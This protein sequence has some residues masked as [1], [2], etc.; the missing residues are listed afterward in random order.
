M[1]CGALI[2]LE[3][4]QHWS[5][6]TCRQAKIEWTSPE[7]AGI[8]AYVAGWECKEW[9]GQ[10]SALLLQLCGQEDGAV[11]FNAL[12]PWSGMG[13]DIRGAKLT[14]QDMAQQLIRTHQSLG[15]RKYYGNLIGDST[16][17]GASPSICDG[18]QE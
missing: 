9:E 6:F 8:P 18:P 14:T 1:N 7:H 10:P 17:R 15:L 2:V 13:S 3:L 5:N 11:D 12:L 4:R 16:L